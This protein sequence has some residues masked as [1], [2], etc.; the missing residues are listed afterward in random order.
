MFYLDECWM[1]VNSSFEYL[2]K[3][4][5]SFK[6]GFTLAHQ[7]I[8]SFPSIRT[9]KSIISN[10]NTKIGML[11][12]GPEETAMLAD[13]HGISKKDFLELGK[14][15][16]WV[17][18]LNR[19]SLVKTFPPPVPEVMEVPPELKVKQ[20]QDEKGV[21]AKKL[22][23]GNPEIEEKSVVNFLKECWFPC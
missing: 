16:A 1:G 9:L 11:P 13:V 3:F 15:Q 23:F 2:L 20:R 7:E 6:V 22:D 17:R 12:A 10:C 4:G 5:R 18:I 19:N 8:S 14:H 21:N